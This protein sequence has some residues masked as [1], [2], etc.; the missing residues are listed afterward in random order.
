MIKP[1]APLKLRTR[2]LYLEDLGAFA[3]TEP[4]ISPQSIHA[5]RAYPLF[6]ILLA[7]GLAACSTT[8]QQVEE[9]LEHLAASEIG[10]QPWQLAVDELASIG[11]PA[12]SSITL[13][14]KRVE[15]IRAWIIATIRLPLG[16]DLFIAAILQVVLS[17]NKQ[18]SLRHR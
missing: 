17:N 2:S 13:P 18:P 1:L 9:Q 12:R 3:M 11:R 6:C 7:W 15:P 8:D 10:T 4:R 16:P 5:R 14:G